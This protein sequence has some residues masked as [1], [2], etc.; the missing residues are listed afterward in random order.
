MHFPPLD[1]LDP[2]FSV[3]AAVLALALLAYLTFGEPFAGRAMY[4]RLQR[5][6]TLV[7]F[8][9]WTLVFQAA[10][11]LVTF[12]VV[13]VAPGVDAQDVGLAWPR[14]PWLGWVAGF[15]AYLVGVIVV[16]G[17]VLRRRALRGRAVPGQAAIADLLPVTRVERRYAAAAAVGA[18]VAEELA[19]RGLL[20][21]T[22]VGVFG[23]DPLVAAPILA[24]GFGVAH[25][26]QGFANV[27]VVA[28][29]GLVFTAL[30]LAT[31]SLLF[32][33]L[34]HVALDLRGLVAVPRSTRLDEA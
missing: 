14:G 31:G 16:T 33:I 32:P 21:A 27:F 24:V 4:R 18:G 9:R 6:G 22:L 1:W 13:A 3:P 19:F 20:I 12:A 29:L 23:L 5:R 15:T 30:Y 2:D 17:V 8:Y 28:L 25:L 11:A 34:A 26:Y 10:L 7:W